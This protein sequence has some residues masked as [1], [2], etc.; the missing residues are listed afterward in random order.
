[1]GGQRAG[2]APRG[3]V[4]QSIGGEHR[5]VQAHA[6]DDRQ[7]DGDH[8]DEADNAGTHERQ[9]D[10]PDG[11]QRPDGTEDPMLAVTLHDW[12][13]QPGADESTD[14]RSGEGEPV[15]P[16]WESKLAQ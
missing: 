9:T 12:T 7:L 4:F 11:A 16:W 13:R 1:P 6:D 2:D 8:G 5:V 14:T 3:G 10:Q 15:L